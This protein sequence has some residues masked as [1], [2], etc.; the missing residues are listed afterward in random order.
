MSETAPHEATPPRVSLLL[1]VFI[2][3]TGTLAMH[4]FVP[5]MP[6]AALELGTDAQTI[7][8]AITI[9]I[10][11]LAAGQ[12]I[13]GPL[14][15]VIGRRAA[16]LGAISIYIV[17]SIASGLA[18]DPGFLMVARFIQALGGAGGLSLTRV[19]VA[20]TSKGVGATKGIAVLNMILLLG[21]GLA[22]VIGAGLSELVGWR[23]IFAALTVMA[24]VTLAVALGKLPE[25]GTPTRRF[26]IGSAFGGFRELLGNGAF[27]RVATGGAFGSTACYGYFVSAPFILGSDMGL[28]VQA[29]GYCIGGTLAAAAA[30][31]LLTRS[32][33][34]KVSEK[35]IQRVFSLLGLTTGLVFLILAVAH[36]LTPVLVVGLSLLVLFSAGGLGPVTIG[37]SLRLAGSRAA[38][39]S[40]LYG[41]FQ[42]LSGVICSFVAG[43]FVD[44]QL[45]CGLVLFGGYLICAVQLLR[46]ARAAA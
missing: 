6:R 14:S 18:T 41:C 33:V 39:A 19:I 29:V 23:G 21:P 11:G 26:G 8:M 25:T 13:Y 16:V 43:L 37:Q 20:D 9:Y 34:G 44:H 24:G 30:G 31:T 27:M 35:T 5:A 1:L 42:M 45:G 10:L 4:I 22:P 2:A 28:N 15:D 7:Q 3:F 32:I 12:L 46:P 36:L 38:S 17:G 40:G